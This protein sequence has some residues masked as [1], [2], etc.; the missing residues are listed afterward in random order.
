MRAQAALAALISIIAVAVI[1][2]E[3]G[4]YEA[5][6]TNSLG[7]PH[8]DP[9]IVKVDA[10]V[11]VTKLGAPGFPKT[12]VIDD[13][14][15]D[16]QETISF[17]PQ[18]ARV[19]TADFPNVDFYAALNHVPGRRKYVSPLAFSLIRMEVIQ[20]L[21]HA[22]LVFDPP[23]YFSGGQVT[24]VGYFDLRHA[25]EW[26]LVS[27]E[28]GAPA[29]VMRMHAIWFYAQVGTLERSS[30]FRSRLANPAGFQPEEHGGSTKNYGERGKDSR[31]E[32]DRVSRQ[33]YPEGFI[34]WLLKVAGAAGLIILGIPLALFLNK[35]ME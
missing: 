20:S 17:L 14:P 4:R 22:E 32:S 11:A 8:V 23:L 35:G 28:T 15:P 9:D 13:D 30:V 10:I 33:P 6:D 3:F 24:G 25:L 5:T 29:F 12:V 26:P 18:F 2:S 27:R 31:K 7:Q 19:G 34:E 16:I 1:S 21:I